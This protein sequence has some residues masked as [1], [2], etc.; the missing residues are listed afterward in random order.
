M[1]R[2]M[3]TL[4]RCPDVAM[5]CVNCAFLLLLVSGLTRC[6]ANRLVLWVPA[7]S[8]IEAERKDAVAGSPSEGS[9]ASASAFPSLFAFGGGPATGG[10]SLPAGLRVSTSR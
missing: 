9:P 4:L 2:T 8:H 10:G 7:M 5:L 6:Q 1:F 3:S